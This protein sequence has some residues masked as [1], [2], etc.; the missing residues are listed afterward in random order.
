MGRL[1]VERAATYDDPNRM[2]YSVYSRNIEN[3]RYNEYNADHY[4][5]KSTVM[6]NAVKHALA[7]L[8]PY[9][10]VELAQRHGSWLWEFVEKQ[11]SEL[12]SKRNELVRE[13]TGNFNRTLGSDKFEAELR[14]LVQSGHS[15][16][17]PEIGENLAK[18]FKVKW[19]YEQA[20]NKKHDMVYLRVYVH[21]D[22]QLADIATIPHK[23]T[24]TL[25]YKH[26]S[27]Q[28]M[29]TS[30]QAEGVPI[31]QLSD[32]LIGR[33]SVLSMLQVEQGEPGVGFKASDS[34]FFIYPESEVADA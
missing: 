6:K 16:T 17:N 14:H 19:A 32:N 24:E 26:S 7:Y 2:E 31:E 10:P 21:N 8:R 5:K 28:Y 9:K 25:Q 33:V 18:Y 27:V 22:Q 30:E 20:E 4:S 12:R 1:D 15:F 23:L 3:K 13:V 34:E 29:S 11:V